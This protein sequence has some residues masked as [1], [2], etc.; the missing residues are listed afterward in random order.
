DRP[1]GGVLVGAAAHRVAPLAE[2]HLAERVVLVSRS[3]TAG[4]E[5]EDRLSGQGVE[6]YAVLLPG[7]GEGVV[8]QREVA[9]PA[10]QVV[11][12]GGE[13]RAERVLQH[14]LVRVHVG[15]RSRSP[16]AACGSVGSRSGTTPRSRQSR[17]AR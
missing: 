14:P 11:D 3:F 13:G 2:L 1:V 8:A 10:P 17:S 15:P 12:S 9:D 6:I 4:P 16:A 7:L 5:V